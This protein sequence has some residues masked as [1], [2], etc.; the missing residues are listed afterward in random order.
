VDKQIKVG[1]LVRVNSPDAS[2]NFLGY[3]K[4]LKLSGREARIKIFGFFQTLPFFIDELEPTTEKE[5]KRYFMD[6]LRG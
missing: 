6:R 3:G 1:D 4:V 2:C 5:Q